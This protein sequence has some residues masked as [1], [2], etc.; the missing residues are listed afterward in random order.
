MKILK[1]ITYQINDEF[2]TIRQF[3]C[4][5]KDEKLALEKAKNFC[6]NR[7]DCVIIPIQINLYDLLGDAP[8]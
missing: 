6:H 2:G 5:D 8:F 4:N 3:E 1:T 7:Q